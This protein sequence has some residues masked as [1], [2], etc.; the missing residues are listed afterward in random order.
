MGSSRVTAADQ[1]CQLKNSM[2]KFLLG[3]VGLA[4]MATTSLKVVADMILRG[5]CAIVVTRGFSAGRCRSRR[6]L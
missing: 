3:A 5:K 2:N 4:A 1:S 6:Y